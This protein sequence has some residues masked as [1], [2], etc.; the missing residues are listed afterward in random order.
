MG[1]LQGRRGGIDPGSIKEE[2]TIVASENQHVFS[3]TDTL[4]RKQGNEIKV[5]YVVA[6]EREAPGKL[7]LGTIFKRTNNRRTAFF[8]KYTEA[9]GKHTCFCY[10][11]LRFGST[12][13]RSR[14]TQTSSYSAL[15]QY[16]VVRALGFCCCCC[17]FFYS[18]LF[19]GSATQFPNNHTETHFF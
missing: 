16:P 1:T 4:R 3:V 5:I 6:E 19:G 7:L 15:L 11:V 14:A 13:C 10:T 8:K 9:R 18:L 12:Q 17:L 2:L